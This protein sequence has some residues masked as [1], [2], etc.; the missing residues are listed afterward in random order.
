MRMLVKL[1][2][3][4]AAQCVT[5]LVRCG[6]P[7]LGL[8][9]LMME[10]ALSSKPARQRLLK[11]DSVARG[12]DALSAR[13]RP[14][15]PERKLHLRAIRRLGAR[16]RPTD[17][18]QRSHDVLLPAFDITTFHDIDV[19]G[20][21]EILCAPIDR[22]LYDEI[23]LGDSDRYGCK[24]SGIIPAQSVGLHLPA[25][26]DGRVV[27]AHSRLNATYMPKA[28]HL[29][30]DHSSNYF[31]WLL[32]CLPRAIVALD[33]TEY[34]DYP[35][36]VDTELPRQ[37]VEALR[38][39][40]GT[41]EIR[42][43]DRAEV[44]RVG[45]L[46]FPGMFSFTHDY[47][48]KSVSAQDFVIAPEAVGLLR[49]KLLSPSK[50]PSGRRVYIARDRA[51]YRRLLNESQVQDLLRAFGF[52][53]VRPED[54]SFTEQV[55]LFSDA[56]AIVGPTGAG[57]ANVVFAPASCKVIVLAGETRDANYFIFGQLGQFLGHELMY[58]TGNAR[59]PWHLHSDYQIDLH[60]LAEA[61]SHMEL[62]AKPIGIEPQ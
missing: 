26:W 41:R 29:C 45:E 8:A 43:I 49:D 33:R 6:F 3:K 9:V 62:T 44:R 23:A 47:Y 10:H 36:L 28:I 52:E 57:M 35:L 40:C 21:T 46:V 2:K 51:R 61:L 54:L 20:G 1:L 15:Y 34:S 53:T 60:Q 32:E 12:A 59:T 4:S 42:S 37:N 18:D 31:H 27:V 25:C 16:V 5:S 39:L 48:G 55:G 30:K 11:F 58:V 56:A 14:I 17:L 38:Q 22:L 24:A 19:I 50:V 13:R 7:R